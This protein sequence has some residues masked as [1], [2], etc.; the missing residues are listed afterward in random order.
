MRDPIDVLK[1][2]WGYSAFRPLQAEVVSSVMAGKDTLA[3]LPTGGG[4]SLCFQVPALAS[5]KLCLVVSPLISLM[6]DQVA[7]LRSRGV[8]AIALTS[9]MRYAEIDNALETAALG[10]TQFLY[11]SP[12]RLGSEMFR[13]RLHRLPLGLIAVD[14]A[15]CVSQW[16]YDFRPSYLRIRELRDVHPDVP[17]LALTATATP[18]VAK[19]VM[20]QL[21][22]RAPNLMR[23]NFH[24]KELTFWVS[25]GEDK[26]GRLLRI[27]DRTRTSGIVYV[28]D[29][30]STVRI[31]GQLSHA[32]CSAAAYHAGLTF[33]QRDTVQQGWMSGKIRFVVATNAF[34]MG[35]DKG[36]VQTVVH[37]DAP[38]D[39]ESYYQ[40]AGRAGRNGE[41]AYAILL[42]SKGDAQ[43]LTERVLGSFP[44]VDEV[45]TVY[46]AFANEHRIALGSG[47]DE[48]YALD[49]RG[50]MQRT[51]ATAS[52]V[53]NALKTLE[54]NGDI[55]LSEGVKDPSRVMMLAAQSTIHG[56]RVQG[57][58]NSALLEALLRG[59]GGIFEAPV[60]IEEDRLARMAQMTPAQV[61]SGLREL[62]R[63]EVLTYVKRND[64]PRVTLL[65]PRRDAALIT[66][67]PVALGSRKERALERLGIMV[68]YM[69]ENRQ[70]RE[71]TL[72][73]YFGEPDIRN[74]G[75]CDVCKASERDTRAGSLLPTEQADGADLTLIR[76]AMDE[77]GEANTRID[78]QA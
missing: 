21:G 39:P 36:D 48:T 30:R 58:R 38:A 8:K 4:K 41:P 43:R 51:G 68:A 37:W 1:A 57:N 63:T 25:H 78:G 26:L 64:A 15:H 24:R 28:R 72:L 31:A 53:N 35:I 69:T 61:E 5:G 56:M 71:R 33:E 6:K 46:Q 14:E 54:L 22:F 16:G 32:G 7:G 52:T 18:T 9:G 17:V 60:I 66:P 70:C 23:G 77:D 2:H 19:D 75:R 40:E 13:A 27:V 49:I 44:T 20:D 55:A 74:C 59:H 34:G 45:R 47:L 73:N 3:L 76:W 62:E 42:V 12:E 10:K 11:V 29:R 67:D 50:L 65:T